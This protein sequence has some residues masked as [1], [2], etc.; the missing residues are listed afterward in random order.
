M[1]NPQEQT[2]FY[3]LICAGG[4]LFHPPPVL[5]QEVHIMNAL[6]TFVSQIEEYGNFIAEYKHDTC[7]ERRYRMD[8]VTV[9][10]IY[11]V[12]NKPRQ[13]SFIYG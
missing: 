9:A 2:Y 12:N 1:F 6:K 5:S 7:I 10:C 13:A 4:I 11:Y 8:T 3:Y